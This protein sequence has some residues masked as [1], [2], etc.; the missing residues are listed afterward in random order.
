VIDL[1]LFEAFECPERVEARERVG[2]RGGEA[3]ERWGRVAAAVGNEQ[4][5]RRTQTLRCAS[6]STS[7]SSL[8]EP[9]RGDLPATAAAAAG[10]AVPA[11]ADAPAPGVATTR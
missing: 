3:F 11:P 5:L 6:A 2:T 4:P 8:A 1:E 7:T 9:R 10:A